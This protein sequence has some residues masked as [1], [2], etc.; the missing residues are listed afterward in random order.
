MKKLAFFLV[1]LAALIISYRSYGQVPA[2]KDELAKAQS[3]AKQ[4]N[5]AEASGVYTDIMGKY[6]HNRD[7]VQG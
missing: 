1:P 4:G 2:L 3:L 6:P 5:I 7:A